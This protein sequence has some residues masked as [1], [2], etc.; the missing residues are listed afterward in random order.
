MQ[1]PGGERIIIAASRGRNGGSHF[2]SRY[3]I[4]LLSSLIPQSYS[5]DEIFELENV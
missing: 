5:F 4:A 2:H 1:S 3:A